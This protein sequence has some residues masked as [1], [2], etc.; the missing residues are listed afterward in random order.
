[1]DPD[2]STSNDTSCISQEIYP[3]GSWP[4]GLATNTL[5][6]AT[7]P[8]TEPAGSN[9][10]L[11][12]GAIAGIVIGIV[13]LLL[14]ILLALFFVRRRKRRRDLKEQKVVS[15]D[16]D[17]TEGETGL[18]RDS[19]SMAEPYHR[20]DPFIS[21]QDA[22][23]LQDDTASGTMTSAG[24]AG[25]GARL[26]G[27]G[28]RETTTTNDTPGV[29]GPLPTK[30]RISDSPSSPSQ[31]VSNS[32]LKHDLLSHSSSPRTPTSGQAGGPMRVI[33]HDDPATLPA[34]P[35]GARLSDDRSRRRPESGPTFRR[36][37][38]AGRVPMNRP[39]EEDVVDLPPLYT[40]VPRDGDVEL[41]NGGSPAE[42]TSAMRRT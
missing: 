38:D 9:K 25:L 19:V 17:L 39:H 26:S 15:D 2:P 12:G 3:T 1:M 29:A 22:V 41:G 40:D 36:H 27:V 23:D 6:A 31:P 5:S 10:G 34:L 24:Y 7:L 14:V 20:L 11:S 37:A 33:N 13:A 18:A 30:S 8:V 16:V 21:G 28:S 32:G 42:E 35:P 4:V